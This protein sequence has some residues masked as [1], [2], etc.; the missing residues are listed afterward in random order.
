MIGLMGFLGW[1][2]LLGL[3]GCATEPFQPVDKPASQA[4]QQ[5]ERSP[6]A[7]LMPPASNSARPESALRLLA[8]G[9]EAFAARAAL[10]ETAGHTLDLQY[11]IIEHDD[12]ATLLLQRLLRAAERGVRVRL[13]VDDL[14]IQQSES[15]LAALAQ[16][17]NIQVRLFNPFHWRG[18]VSRALEWLGSDKRLNQ[19]MHNKL[20]IADSAAAVIGGRN[21]GDAYFDASA[22]GG[23]SDLDLL[24]AGPAVREAAASFDVYWNGAWAVPLSKVVDAPSDGAQALR[25]L[26]QRATAFQTSDYVRILRA[27][28]YGLQLR[29]GSLAMI[30]APAHI[31]ADIPA[32]LPHTDDEGDPA[33]TKVGAIFPALRTAVQAA[34]REVI[35]ISPYFVPGER[36]VDMVC[37]LVARGVAVRVLTNSLASTDVPAVHAGYARYRPRMLACGAELFEK[38]A[39]VGADRPR[40]STG[41]SLHAKAVV[42]DRQWVLMGSMNL[43]ARSRRINTEVALQVDSASL[44]AQLG[45]LFDAST[46]ADLVWRP[47]LAQPGN[48]AAALHWLGSSEGK[49]VVLADEPEASAWRHAAAALLGWLIDEELL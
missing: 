1:I 34:R 27:S 41:S 32:A 42:I 15:D 49:A 44:G 5:P 33:P 20:W 22:Q 38:R 9:Q 2:I 8:T 47:G 17:P 10:A 43:D 6:L 26:D 37:A 45:A 36:S 11:H 21:L 28:E 25:D 35:V 16:H 31:L 24:V 19:R 14:G 23:F 46:T 13:L 29:Q 48:P 12:T 3:S 40:L 30:G 18:L 39:S 7:R 4:F